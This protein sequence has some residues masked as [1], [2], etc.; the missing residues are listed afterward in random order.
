MGARLTRKE[1]QAR[2]RS[3][4]LSSAARIL[5]CKGLHRAS[6][7]EIAADAGYTKGA[8]YANFKSK[9]ELFLVMLDEHFA[10]R[11]AALEQVTAG[12]GD[13]ATQ[14]RQA[15][16]DFVAALRG[17]EEWCRLF[18]EFAS[19]AARHEE[20]RA[21]FVARN[22]TLRD[23]IAAIFERRAAELGVE[24]A[25]PARD[26]A[27]MTFAMAHGVA[28]DRLLD[29]DHTP[30]EM[31]GEMLQLFFTGIAARTQTLADART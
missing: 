6:I 19:H 7:D 29:P 8:F 15:G 2:T 18:L 20:F 26:I 9:E 27:Q 28:I 12:G 23:G 24:P 31:F 14:A 13:M 25:V 17:D 1:Q 4:L 10:E 3:T 16:D 21:E 5:A 11:L 22:H 30:D